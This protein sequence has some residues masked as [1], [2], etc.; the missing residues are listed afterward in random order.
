MIFRNAIAYFRLLLGLMATVFWCS[1]ALLLRPFWSRSVIVLQPFWARTV[2]FF[3]GVK[4]NVRSE[5]SICPPVIYV[6]NHQ[7]GLDILVMIGH[8]PDSV[9]FV[10][11]K[12]LANV[13]FT[14]WC[15]RA[16]DYLF[17]DRDNPGGA[18]EKLRQAG[19]EIRSGGRS[20]IMFPEG[21]RYPS[22]HLGPFKSGA[23]YLALAAET[24]LV[25]V[26]IT[27]TGELMERK[28]LLCHSGHVDINIGPL[29]NTSHWI[30]RE[31]ELRDYMRDEVKRLAGKSAA[32]D[33]VSS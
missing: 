17:I 16:A 2:L 30:G 14:G 5:E 8:M 21:T 13:P 23:F 4:V 12:Q 10:A 32:L 22:G 29:I 3:A 27:N 24:A 20:V 7:S 33:A 31:N 6:A 15:M 9:R 26:G 19:A 1:L 11:K 25:P 18:R 28:S